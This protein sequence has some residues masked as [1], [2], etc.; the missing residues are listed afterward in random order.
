V[1]IEPLLQDGI[2]SAV[3]RSY[4]LPDGLDAQQ[5]RD[6]LKLGGFV[7]YAGQ[8]ELAKHIFRVSTMGQIES[9]DI[10]QYIRV[11]GEVLL[12]RIVHQ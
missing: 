10:D 3:L 2:S 7:I 8:G 1:G 11:V 12:D 9:K 5:F 6:A 4:H